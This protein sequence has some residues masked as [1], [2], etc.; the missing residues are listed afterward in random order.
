[1]GNAHTKIVEKVENDLRKEIYK[2]LT[3][4]QGDHKVLGNM[5]PQDAEGF[6][7]YYKFRIH[8]QAE[9]GV[10]KLLQR[11]WLKDKSMYDKSFITKLIWEDYHFGELFLKYA[12]SFGY[13][14]KYSQPFFETDKHQ[15]PQIH[16]RDV[17]N[18][19]KGGSELDIAIGTFF[20]LPDEYKTEEDWKYVYTIGKIIAMDPESNLVIYRNQRDFTI[21]NIRNMEVLQR[22]IV[23]YITMRNDVEGAQGL[24]QLQHY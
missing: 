24:L 1:M 9:R 14:R 3:E 11:Y 12:G 21:G 20:I 23:Q 2:Y 16:P 8:R 22:A 7:E 15:G 6:L 5:M 19:F 13:W 18:I 10:E 17:K 4:G